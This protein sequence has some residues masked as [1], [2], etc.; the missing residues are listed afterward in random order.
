M[1]GR[2]Q[3]VWNEVNIEAAQRHNIAVA[4]RKSGGGTVFHDLGN[5]NISFVTHRKKYDRKWNLQ[6]VASVLRETWGLDVD[7]TERDDMLLDGKFKVQTQ[8]FDYEY[9]NLTVNMYFVRYLAQQR[10]L[11]EKLHITISRC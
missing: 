4:R 8:M 9:E 5:L 3:N 1:I 11:V 6:L 2:H 7:V 10:S